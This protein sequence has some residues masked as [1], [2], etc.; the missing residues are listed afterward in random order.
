MS[1]FLPHQ[2]TL[3]WDESLNLRNRKYTQPYENLIRGVG[4]MY[5]E[6]YDACKSTEK[7]LITEISQLPFVYY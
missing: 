6:M 2:D 3:K 1:S 7:A 4:S 5:D